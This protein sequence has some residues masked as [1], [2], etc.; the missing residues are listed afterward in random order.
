M[1]ID[2]DKLSER[3]LIDLR[4]HRRPPAFS[5][6]DAG[7]CGDRVSFHPAGQGPVAGTLTRYNKKTVTVITDDG[8]QWNVSPNLLSKVLPQGTEA[9]PSNLVPLRRR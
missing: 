1:Q 5:W 3:E 8:R 6:D 2:V 7:S 4:S 9:T